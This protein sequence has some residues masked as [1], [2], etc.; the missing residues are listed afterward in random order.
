LIIYST[1]I[2]NSGTI[3]VNG[4]A[5]GTGQGTNSYGGGGGGS[6]KVIGYIGND[7]TV[8]SPAPYFAYS[9][10]NPDGLTPS[11]YQID[12]SKLNWNNMGLSIG[13]GGTAGSYFPIGVATPGAS[14]YLN[15]SGPSGLLL[16]LE[17]KGG[18]Q[19]L[20]PIGNNTRQA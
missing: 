14:T 2:A 3:A 10:P 7:P 18:N 8:I 5:G 6:G 19:G 15:I 20:F 11:A 1:L 9:N 4:G 12:L 13:D 16:S 17:A